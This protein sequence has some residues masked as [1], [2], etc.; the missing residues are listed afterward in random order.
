MLP[1]AIQLHIILISQF[2]HSSTQGDRTTMHSTS[3]TSTKFQTMQGAL[4]GNLTMARGQRS[5]NI[6]LLSIMLKRRRELYDISLFPAFMSL[7]AGRYVWEK[8]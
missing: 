4:N 7:A 5:L 1:P 3:I 2:P 8:G 6:I